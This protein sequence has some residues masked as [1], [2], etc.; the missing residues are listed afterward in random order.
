M[1]H[2]F[3]RVRAFTAYQIRSVVTLRRGE[4]KPAL[5]VSGNHS[6]LTTRFSFALPFL[7]QTV[8]SVHPFKSAQVEQPELHNTSDTGTVLR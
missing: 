6:N 4:W 2:C 3:F 8:Q 1:A 7:A 5:R